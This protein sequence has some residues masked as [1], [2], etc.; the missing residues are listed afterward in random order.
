MNCIELCSAKDKTTIFKI[1]CLSCKNI[2]CSKCDDNFFYGNLTL[3]NSIECSGKELTCYNCSIKFAK[4]DNH[5]LY[6]DHDKHIKDCDFCKSKICKIC[7]FIGDCDV[8]DMSYCNDCSV[9]FKCND[10]NKCYC[11][12]C[13]FPME[14]GEKSYCSSCFN[15][16]FDLKDNT[17]FEGEHCGICFDEFG[18]SKSIVQCPDCKNIIHRECM[19]SW[20][21][22]NIS[23]VYCRSDVFNDFLF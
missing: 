21:M 12:D 9:T 4:M 11:L 20:L 17:K 22:H 6:L 18:N 19:K 5:Y 23:C 15:K 13:E 8:C 7:D 3:C 14:R 10:C 2:M 1:A 16:F